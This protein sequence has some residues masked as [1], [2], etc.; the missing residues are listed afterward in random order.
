MRP[1]AR[2]A[3]CACS[4]LLL[5]VAA[6]GGAESSDT[7]ADG[8]DLLSSSVTLP[9]TAVDSGVTEQLAVLC[10]AGG[11]CLLS[12]RAAN[13]SRAV[14]VTLSVVS[15]GHG[16]VSFANAAAHIRVVM[17]LAGAKPASADVYSATAL[18]AVC[19]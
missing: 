4:L 14:N 8:L 5:A 9:C 12:S 16:V 18:E 11:K 3:L 10:S 13:S 7:T 6:C 17:Q 1:S 15:A 19:Q 2:L